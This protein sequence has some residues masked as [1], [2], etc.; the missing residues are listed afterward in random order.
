MANPEDKT[1]GIPFLLFSLLIASVPLTITTYLNNQSDLPKNAA[2]QITGSL[3]II[4]V[5]VVYFRSVLKGSQKTFA[6]LLYFKKSLDP[7]ILLFLFAA[8]ISTVFSLNPE[9]SYTGQYERQYGLVLIIF[10]TLIYFLSPAVYKRENSIPQLLFIMEIVSIAVA[11]YAVLQW[12]GIDPFAFQPVND[13]RPVSF[14]GNAVF[15]GGFLAINL[16]ISLL[17][18]SGKKNLPAKIIF[19]LVIVFGI[20]ATGTRSAYIAVTAAFIVLAFFYPVA[21]GMGGASLKKTIKVSGLILFGGIVLAIAVTIIFNNNPFI[22][23]VLSIFS[24]SD[25]PRFALWRDSFDIFLKYPLFGPG[26]GMFPN[27]LEEFYSLRL[28]NDEIRKYF[29]NA[30]NNYI[31]VLC[32]MGITGLIAYMLILFSSIN[33]SIKGIYSSTEKRDKLLFLSLMCVLAAYAIYG[34]TNFDEIAITLYIFVYLSVIRFVYKKN[35]MQ[36]KWDSKGFL[37]TSIAISLIILSFCSYSTYNIINNIRADRYYLEG[38]KYF[39]DQKF[40]E[41]VNKINSAILLNSSCG[42]FRYN[43]AVNVYGFAV[44][45]NKL[46]VESKSNLLNQAAGEM[47]RARKTFISINSCDAI[48]AMIY[49]E[50]GDINKADSTKNEVFKRDPLSMNFRL[51]LIMYYS[52]SDQMDKARENMKQVLKTGFESVGVWNA[53]AYY[54]YKTGDKVKAS[55]YYNK[56]LSAEPGNKAVIDMLEKLK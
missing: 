4:S 5:I 25:N 20:A 15:T 30:H 8:L 10:I 17:N 42:N 44:T 3:F 43:L 31:Q 35:T 1:T 13:K 54:Y 2:L 21:A 11:A 9:I 32:T 18:T 22:L 24:S 33:A 40:T 49:Y 26:I 19:P 16:P 39:S 48:L 46:S 52:K 36:Y 55:F 56:V 12:C 51:N 41:G 50:Q 47:L 23:R 27:A 38:I 29:D 34:L 7:F 53:A 28:R 45:N 6:G 37:F 14:L